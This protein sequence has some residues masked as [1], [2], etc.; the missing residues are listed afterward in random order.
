MVRS[1]FSLASSS[2]VELIIGAARDSLRP[3]RLAM[4]STMPR[5]RNRSAVSGADAACSVACSAFKNSSGFSR[6]RCRRKGRL[7]RQAV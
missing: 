1:I 2:S 3:A 4:A 6:I 7:L 5:S